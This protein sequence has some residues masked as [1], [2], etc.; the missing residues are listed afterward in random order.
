MVALVNSNFD[1]RY[2]ILLLPQGVA[3]APD[4]LD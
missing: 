4:G 3:D 1:Q 2:V